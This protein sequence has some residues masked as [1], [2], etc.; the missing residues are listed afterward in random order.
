ML[1]CTPTLHV[2]LSVSPSIIK[3]SIFPL[4]RCKETKKTFRSMSVDLPK[5][6]ITAITFKKCVNN[7]LEPFS[8]FVSFKSM[9]MVNKSLK[10]Y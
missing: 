2:C 4:P 7:Q 3:R 9:T 10:Y 6:V 5:H 8:N 1:M